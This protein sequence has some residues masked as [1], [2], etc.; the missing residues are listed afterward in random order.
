MKKTF[1]SGS[2]SRRPRHSKAATMASP[3]NIKLAHAA[4]K[5]PRPIVDHLAEDIY[6]ELVGAYDEMKWRHEISRC[7]ARKSALRDAKQIAQFLRRLKS[8]AR[9]S[10]R[11]REINGDTIRAVVHAVLNRTPRSREETHLK[12]VIIA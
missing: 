1:S 6:A 4:A 3:P 11:I 8:D 9:W 5:R 10:H 2:R 12:T 7:V